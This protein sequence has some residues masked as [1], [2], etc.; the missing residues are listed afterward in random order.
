MLTMMI[1]LLT[2]GMLKNKFMHWI[3][4]LVNFLFENMITK[5]DFTCFMLYNFV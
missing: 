5:I 3:L 2:N 1:I 4:K